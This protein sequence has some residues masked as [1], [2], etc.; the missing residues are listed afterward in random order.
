MFIV[1]SGRGD[2]LRQLEHIIADIRDRVAGLD[3][4]VTADRRAANML[5]TLVRD[6]NLANTIRNVYGRER[7]RRIESTLEPQCLSG[8]S[9]EERF[10]I[11][12]SHVILVVDAGEFVFADCVYEEVLQGLGPI[13]DE[14]SVPWS[15]FND[16]VQLGFFGLYNQ[17]LVNILYH[18]R[19]RPGMTKDEAAAVLP[20]ILP[21]VRVFVL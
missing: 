7:A 9:K 2:R 8:F 5:V 16:N 4:G 11:L 10:R 1:D 20:E 21:E 14:T 12:H 3:I 17:Y 13:N 18:P 19:L 6:R 15:M